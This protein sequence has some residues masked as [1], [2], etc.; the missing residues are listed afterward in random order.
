MVKIVFPQGFLW[1][2]TT[3]SYQVEGAWPSEQPTRWWSIWSPKL[4]NSK[5]N[6]VCSQTY[7]FS[8]QVFKLLYVIDNLGNVPD[9][10]EIYIRY[11]QGVLEY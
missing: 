10:M 2:V 6:K 5:F 11:G 1:G 9:G 4:H 7:Y 8:K 3:S